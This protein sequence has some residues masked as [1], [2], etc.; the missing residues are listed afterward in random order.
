MFCHEWQVT[1]ALHVKSKLNHCE[2]R[3]QI[4]EHKALPRTGA[5]TPV[6]WVAS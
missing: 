1:L 5:E 2:A 6:E 3:P 4:A